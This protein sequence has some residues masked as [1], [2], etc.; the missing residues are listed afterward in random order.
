M[1]GLFPLWS[2]FFN[3]YLTVMLIAMVASGYGFVISSIAPSLEA[4]NALAAPMMIP[5]MIF[6]GF[7]I[8]T[9]STP[10][11]FIWIKYLSWF[12]YGFN[13]LIINQWK[14]GGYCAPTTEVNSKLILSNKYLQ[15]LYR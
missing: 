9:L 6:G 4:A 3:Q 11:Y 7:F 15:H 8:R 2:V 1:F 5:F 10:Y 12:Y 14:H 13:N